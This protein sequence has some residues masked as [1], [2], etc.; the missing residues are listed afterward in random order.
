GNSTR[1]PSPV[2]RWPNG[3]FSSRV[4]ARLWVHP[5]P[6]PRSTSRCADEYDRRKSSVKRPGSQRSVL[7]AVNTV[8]VTTS[9][10]SPAA[11]L[12]PQFGHPPAP[13]LPQLPDPLPSPLPFFPLPLPS[14]P[15]PPLP[16][17]PSP[18]PSPL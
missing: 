17:S 16:P 5:N 12:C 4:H 15:A 3:P 7:G 6:M 18:S 9:T 10:G 8:P 14:P 1:L 2:M 13:P 11:T